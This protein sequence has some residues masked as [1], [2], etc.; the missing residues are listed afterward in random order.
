MIFPAYGADGFYANSKSECYVDDEGNDWF[1]FCGAQTQSCNGNKVASRNKITWV[2]H[3]DY[4]NW[5]KRGGKG[6]YWCCNGTTSSSGRFVQGTDWIVREESRTETLPEGKCT[7]IAKI[8]ICGDVDNTDDKCTEATGECTQGLVSHN[9]KCVVACG[10]GQAFASDTSSSCISC[11]STATQGISKGVCIK[12]EA[13]Q[14][15]DLETLSCVARSSKLQVSANAFNKCWMCS[16]PGATYECLKTLSTN[17][18]LDSNSQLQKACSVN[19]KEQDATA[20]HTKSYQTQLK[21][22]NKPVS[23]TT[24]NFDLKEILTSTSME[25]AMEKAKNNPFKNKQ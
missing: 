24:E 18:T 3:G 7:W 25:D 4:F 16:T 19:S 12:C 21:S 9:G 8:N 15:F 11:D 13:N 20:L 6:N 2:Y 23:T 17:R 10:D 1:W 5:T 22:E 14:F